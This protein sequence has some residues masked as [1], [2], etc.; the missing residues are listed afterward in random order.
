[1]AYNRRE[2]L[3]AQ[4]PDGRKSDLV[5]HLTSPCHTANKANYIARAK[6]K[7]DKDELKEL[8]L[9][10]KTNVDKYRMRQRKT[11]TG[12]ACIDLYLKSKKPGQK[13][14]K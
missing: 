13:I 11:T 14:D 2:K 7:R 10:P 8:T 6:A 4:S 12:D 5:G 3:R 1:M 9:H